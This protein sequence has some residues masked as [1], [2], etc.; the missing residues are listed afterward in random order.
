[1]E[2]DAGTSP[3]F[4]AY[5]PPAEAA[6]AMGC[7]QSQLPLLSVSVQLV[8]ARVHSA[9]KKQLTVFAGLEARAHM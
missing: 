3:T 4:V 6:R 5:T 2:S 8:L 1:M 7:S 9:A